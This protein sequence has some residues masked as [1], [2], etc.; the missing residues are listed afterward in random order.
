MNK[1]L[2]TY[3]QEFH[4]PQPRAQKTNVVQLPPRSLG[5]AASPLIT[6]I[7]EGHYDVQLSQGE[8]VRLITWSD[9]NAPYYGSYFGRRNLTYRD[10]PDFRPI[11]TLQSASGIPP[12][13]YE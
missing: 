4:G 1:K 7:R 6:L 11:P 5:S 8:L 2:V 3:I 12:H 10:H 13:T 9:A